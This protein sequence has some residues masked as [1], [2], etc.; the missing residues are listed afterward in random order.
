M[1]PVLRTH[2][3]PPPWFR[4]P[5]AGTLFGSARK[6]SATLRRRKHADLF[7]QHTRP[8]VSPAAPAGT[9]ALPQ[10][11]DRDEPQE[12]PAAQ[13]VGFSGGFIKTSIPD[14]HRRNRSDPE[15]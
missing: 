10:T 4:R 8:D 7:P 2:G 11:S 1:G 13:T 15:T 5:G 14:R 12:S 9:A 6:I 3:V